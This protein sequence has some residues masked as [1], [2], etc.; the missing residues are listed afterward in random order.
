M[1]AGSGGMRALRRFAQRSAQAER[2]ALCNV[3]L[4]LKHFHLLELASRRLVCGCQACAVLFS[5]EHG[6]RYRQVPRRIER[7]TNFH[8]SD[9]QWDSLQVP[10]DLV[11]FY[12]H[13]AAGKIVAQYPSPAGPMESLLSLDAWRT[14][15]ADNPILNEFE[16]DVEA[17]LVNRTDQARDYY[18]LPIDE[19]YRLVGLVRLHWKGFSG[20]LDVREAIGQFLLDCKNGI[21]HEPTHRER[22]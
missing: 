7:L 1:D 10:I 19:C 4:P 16:P 22:S 18:R 20:G 3:E 15:T 21:T 12:H 2:C 6:T 11:F 13:S 5:G 14:L 8:M 9:A 17:L